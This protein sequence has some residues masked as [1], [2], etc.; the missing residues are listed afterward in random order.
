MRR[1]TDRATVAS[2]WPRAFAMLRASTALK[3]TVLTDTSR[4]RDGPVTSHDAEDDPRNADLKMAR[5]LLWTLVR[6]DAGVGNDV[7]L[8]SEY[9]IDNTVFA[10]DEL[11]L[12]F[13]E[14]HP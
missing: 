2:T 10:H 14:G 1:I 11:P 8:V 12:L 6:W 7:N 13:H 3:G 9:A 4:D 5:V